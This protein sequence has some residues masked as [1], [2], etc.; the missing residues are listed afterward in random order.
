[1]TAAWKRLKKD[2]KGFTL[3]ELLAVIVILGII[4]A[5]A[6]PLIGNILNNS[7]EKSDFQTARQVYD[8]ARLYGTTELNGEFT[9]NNAGIE[10]EISEA[11]NK[12]GLKEKGYLSQSLT[13]PSTKE[14]IT[15]G[16]VKF[17]SSG[18]ILYV[19][20]KTATKD[21]FFKGSEVIKGEGTAVND[22]ENASK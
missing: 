19:H 1:M 16:S 17:D 18:Q 6:I 9:K 21:K 4:A 5:I 7:R 20:L 15:D 11:T 22:A 12:T 14:P 8:A 3:I 2:E 13:L 10:V